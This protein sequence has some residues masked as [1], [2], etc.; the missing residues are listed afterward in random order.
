M[1]LTKEKYA[2][3]YLA[4]LTLSIY[5]PKYGTLDRMSTQFFLLSVTN[6]IAILSIPFVFRFN[7]FNLKQLYKNPLIISYS[8]IILFALLSIFK[9][10]NVVESFVVLNQLFVFFLCLVILIFLSN[11]KL[12]KKKTVL[13]IIFFSLVTDISF[14]L[15]PF[16]EL[17]TNDLNYSYRYVTNFVGL[18]GNRNILAL[19]ILFRIPLI[20]Y[21][22]FLV[23]N[24]IIKSVFSF[25]LILAF[26]NIYVL[27]SR[28]ALLGI[29]LLIFL[30]LALLFFKRKVVLSTHL[31]GLAVF[32]FLP[33]ILSYIISVNVISNSDRARVDSRVAS[34]VSSSDESINSRLR[35]WSHATD[36]ISKNPLLGAG[37]GNW[38]IYSI[39]YDAPYIKS[40]IVP[41][42]AH[43]DILEFTAETGLIGGLF[44]IS[45]FILIFLKILKTII[46][47]KYDYD[48]ILAFV[49]LSSLLIYFIDLNLNFPSSR[50]LNLYF[51]LLYITIVNIMYINKHEKS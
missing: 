51:L 12:I 36:F 4:L 37:I 20:I 9:S 48:P 43:N 22:A 28:A 24:K 26:F 1:K 6:F 45:F 15:F 27:S 16:Y 29:I 21:L 3:I 50:P 2:L 8:G 44:F 42:N 23:K 17:W 5:T 14:S 34:I 46:I 41:Y 39:K 25:I 18:A 33:I 19:S 7:K 10:I 35:Y 40:Y 47:H 38:K 13:W 31:K 30:L 11:Q 49:L 32:F